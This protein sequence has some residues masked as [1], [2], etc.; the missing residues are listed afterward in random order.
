MDFKIAGTVDL[1]AG[2]LDNEMIVTLP[3]SKNLPWYAA[4]LG[5]AN[6]LAGIA[7]IAGERVLRGPLEQFSSAKY[8]ISGTLDDPQ[9]D[10]VSIFDTSMRGPDEVEGQVQAATQTG[11][12]KP[13]AIPGSGSEEDGNGNGMEKLPHE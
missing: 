10:L 8:A 7:V 13:A 6:P 11:P 1:V 3:V 2:K 9:V 5:L 12:G 4:F